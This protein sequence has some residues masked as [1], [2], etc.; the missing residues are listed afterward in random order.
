MKNT[1]DASLLPYGHVVFKNIEGATNA[2]NEE[3]FIHGKRVPIKV[4]KIDVQ[5]KMRDT[6]ISPK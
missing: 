5:K 2:K 1:K 6:K 3:H 4:H